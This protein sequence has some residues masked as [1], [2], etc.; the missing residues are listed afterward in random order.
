[1]LWSRT[2]REM[3]WWDKSTIWAMSVTG[4]PVAWGLAPL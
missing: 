4:R 3:C 1:V 2:M